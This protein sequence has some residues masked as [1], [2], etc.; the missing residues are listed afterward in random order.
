M[1]ATHRTALLFAVLSLA[2]FAAGS[3]NLADARL[4]TEHR[5]Y[6]YVTVTP[7]PLCPR[8][9]SGKWLRYAIA[10]QADGGKW[11]IKCG[12]RDNK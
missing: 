7:E 5:I 8:R 2:L 12:Y 3:W 9:P 11:I 10:Q 4:T 1:T 6:H